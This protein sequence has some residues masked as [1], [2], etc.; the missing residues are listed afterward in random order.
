MI[1]FK[2]EK[3]DLCIWLN[4]EMLNYGFNSKM[5]HLPSVIQLYLTKHDNVV[6]MNYDHKFTPQPN[7]T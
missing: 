4:K 7:M 1:M 3:F 5:Q 6:L 2:I